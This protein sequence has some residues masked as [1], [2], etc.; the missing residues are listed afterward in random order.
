MGEGERWRELLVFG[1]RK[2]VDERGEVPRP[3][4]VVDVDDA[5]TRGAAIEHG[6]Q[7]GKSVEARPVS[8]AGGNGDYRNLHKPANHGGQRAL[9]T[10]YRDNNTG[11][12]Q[13]GHLIQKPVDSGYPD[14]ENALDLAVHDLGCDHSLASDGKVGCTRTH[15]EYAGG[16]DHTEFE[17]SSDFVGS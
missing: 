9:H 1:G 12:L 8:H 7:S 3:E 16:E 10:S 11:L 13:R 14:I 2:P 17:Y 4:A 5:Y 6:E 15:D